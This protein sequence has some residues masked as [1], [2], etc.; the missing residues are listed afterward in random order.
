LGII[1]IYHTLGMQ[2]PVKENRTES[3]LIA[4]NP[5]ILILNTD[6]IQL[7][8]M[9]STNKASNNGLAW[10][11]NHATFLNLLFLFYFYSNTKHA[12]ISLQSSVY[13]SSHHGGGISLKHSS[14]GRDSR[15]SD[16]VYEKYEPTLCYLQPQSFI[17]R[18]ADLEPPITRFTMMCSYFRRLVIVITRD[19]CKTKKQAG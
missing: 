10:L 14:T 2:P 19:A 12:T 8:D 5:L 3:T 11:C 15:F 9:N 16:A 13:L 18:L 6:R 7:T 1:D 17:L 4:Q